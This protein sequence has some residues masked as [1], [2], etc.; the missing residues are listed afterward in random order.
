[1][2]QKTISTGKIS[3]LVIIILAFLGFMSKLQIDITSV[4]TKQG[5]F[6]ENVKNF[7]KEN[8]E[9]HKDIMNALQFITKHEK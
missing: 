7:M 5:A 4:T 1:M 6:E 8:R 9:D 3:I 2:T